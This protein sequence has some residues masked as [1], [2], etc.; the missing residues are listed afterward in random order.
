MHKW[1]RMA[2]AAEIAKLIVPIDSDARGDLSNVSEADSSVDHILKN[3][4][5][6]NH[7]ESVSEAQS[8][9]HIETPPSRF[10]GGRDVKRNEKR[11]R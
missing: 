4:T 3:E 8:N 1:L 11:E 10:A 6:S 2:D 5:P 9:L 7:K